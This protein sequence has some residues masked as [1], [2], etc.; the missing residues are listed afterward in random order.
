MLFLGFSFFLIAAALMLVGL[1]FRLNI[2]RR[3][4]EIGL[5]LAVGYR[6]AAVRRLLLGE[7][8]VLAA[9]GAVVGACLAMLYARLLLQLLVA[10]W[11]GQTLQSFLRPHYTPL[12]LVV[13]AG[14]AFLV[15]VLTIVWSVFSLGRVAPSALLAGQ[16][17][18]EST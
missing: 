5:L 9:A 2:D 3:A 1:L 6:R 12:S 14:G 7:G 16:M 11:P 4:D 18:G 17:P 13:G 10:L 15:S 8:C